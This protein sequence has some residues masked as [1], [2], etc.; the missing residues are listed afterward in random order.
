MSILGGLTGNTRTMPWVIPFHI[1]CDFLGDP[2]SYNYPDPSTGYPGGWPVGTSLTG[3]SIAGLLGFNLSATVEIIPVGG[4]QTAFITAILSRDQGNGTTDNI[5]ISWGGPPGSY[6]P[7]GTLTIQIPCSQTIKVENMPGTDPLTG[8]QGLIV[9]S[10]V[11][12]LRQPQNDYCPCPFTIA[13]G[14]LVG[15]G[16]CLLGGPIYDLSVIEFSVTC[17]NFEATVSCSPSCSGMAF[18]YPYTDTET[19]Q[20]HD[21]WHPNTTLGTVK[22][23]T[24]SGIGMTATGGVILQDPYPDPINPELNVWLPV[25]YPLAKSMGF[26]Q[27]IR[28]YKIVGDYRCFADE[29]PDQWSVE[30]F[31][32]NSPPGIPSILKG[33]GQQTTQFTQ[34]SVSCNAPNFPTTR[35][36]D[37]CRVIPDPRMV[38]KG[39][40]SV[41]GTLGPPMGKALSWNAISL[42]CA[43]IVDFFPPAWRGSAGAVATVNT[44]KTVSLNRS[45]K[46]PGLTAKGTFRTDFLIGYRYLQFTIDQLNGATEVVLTMNGKAYTIPLSNSGTITVDLCLPDGAGYNFQDSMGPFNDTS[47]SNQTVVG[48]TTVAT[49]AYNDN[50]Q[51]LASLSQISVGTYLQ[52][53]R[54]GATLEVTGFVGRVVLLSGKV[55]TATGDTVNILSGQ[56]NPGGLLEPISMVGR[57]GLKWTRT[58]QFY[59]NAQPDANGNCSITISGLNLI[60]KTQPKI[61]FLKAFSGFTPYIQ[62]QTLAGVVTQTWLRGVCAMVDNSMAWEFGSVSGLNEPFQLSDWCTYVSSIPGWSMSLVQPGK[63]WQILGLTECDEIGGNGY[64]YPSLVGG[65]TVAATGQDYTSYALPEGGATIPASLHYDYLYVYPG[66]GDIDT[67]VGYGDNSSNGVYRF[68]GHVR[69]KGW[70]IANP[71]YVGQS[72]QL[73]SEVDGTIGGSATIGADGYWETKLPY[74]HD[75]VTYDIQMD[76]KKAGSIG[77][78]GARRN[79]MTNLNIATL[80]VALESGIIGY[81]KFEAGSS[82]GFVVYRS[83]DGVNFEDFVQIDANLDCAEPTTF[84]KPYGRLLGCLYRRGYGTLTDPYTIWRAVSHGEGENGTWV[85]NQIMS[86]Y[87]HAR[88]VY[89]PRTGEWIQ[90]VIDSNNLL[91]S[92]ILD[93]PGNL[94]QYVPADSSGI[95]GI[96]CAD[97]AFDVIYTET[98]GY[99]DVYFVDS[100]GQPHLARSQSEGRDYIE[101]F[102]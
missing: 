64:I 85:T 74:C 49:G 36:Y 27:T 55:S 11:S 32:A 7:S 48:T 14:P 61:E 81:W 92:K 58:V 89:N 52:F 47:P 45:D 84:Y 82:N 6:N 19:Y 41:Y 83:W 20:V 24:N 43:N 8:P 66:E 67:G 39:Y 38:D 25:N 2:N 101:V 17:L 59:F 37:F 51:V 29:F 102:S 44:G 12:Y 79:A 16:V 23:F 35:D 30:Y 1:S 95:L 98:L 57:W 50:Q 15:S 54:A 71:A 76:G 33:N 28:N 80:G 53:V 77:M 94:I 60:R 75:G 34:N 40:G 62:A 100:S 86:G 18:G 99:L 22:Y 87:K 88:E 56:Y 68:M 31:G 97:T 65:I 96:T 4:V 21:I 10:N 63:P 72:L 93:A 90:Y 3:G 9:G 91:Q 5:H 26:S 70:G 13:W 46:R 73:V 69:G 42:A 78:H